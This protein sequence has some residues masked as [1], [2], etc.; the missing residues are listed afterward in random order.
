MLLPIL[1]IKGNHGGDDSVLKDKVTQMDALW[2]PG[3]MLLSL[4]SSATAQTP[5]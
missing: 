2:G 3:R 5:S 1:E 4:L